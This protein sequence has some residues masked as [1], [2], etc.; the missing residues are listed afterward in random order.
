MMLDSAVAVAVAAKS[1]MAWTQF[2]RAAK[3]KHFFLD[4]NRITNQ[5]FRISKQR[6]NTSNEQCASNGNLV[7]KPVFIKA[8]MSC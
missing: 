2:H 7:G 8:K 1:D 6:L 4:K 5:I 3:H